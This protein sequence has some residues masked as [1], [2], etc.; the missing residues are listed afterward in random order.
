MVLRVLRWTGL[1][2]LAGVMLLIGSSCTMLGLNYASLDT[3]NKPV[4]TPP[5]D[6]TALISD[7]AE[8]ARLKGLLQETLYGSWPEGLPVSFGDWR[9]IV[10]D[11]LEGRGTLEELDITIGA[12]PGA[13]TFQ[14]VA[15]FPSG[16]VHAPVVIAQTFGSNCATFPEQPVTSMD[17]DA[18]T[19]RDFGKLAGMIISAVFGE[20]IAE[21]P[22]DLSAEAID[23]DLIIGTANRAMLKPPVRFTSSTRRQSSSFIRGTRASLRMPALLMRM[24][25]VGN[26]SSSRP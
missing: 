7:P 19:V 15:A 6:V 23:V 26:R 24:S 10:P 21:A 16:A 18:C 17:G 9:V 11:Y 4:A 20:Y 3:D 13:R 8:R 25:M 5:I 1:S 12:G 2:L 22:V 14:L